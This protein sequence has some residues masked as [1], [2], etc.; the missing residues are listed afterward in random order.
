MGQRSGLVEDHGVDLRQALHVRATL[1]DDAGARRMRHRGKHRRRRGDADAGAV[2][3]DHQ[4]QEAIEIAGDRRGADREAERWG[5][6]PVGELLGMVLHTGVADR[7]R[8]HEPRD[9]PGGGE[10][11]D[12]D[13]AH[14]Q[15]AVAHN[16]RG[17]HRFALRAHDRCKPS[18]VM[19]F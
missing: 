5:D 3:D 15:L 9:L 8:F 12:A 1:D 17:E 14:G 11:A 16:R 6:Q 2:V 18:P 13:G 7:R 4:R 10:I 19:V